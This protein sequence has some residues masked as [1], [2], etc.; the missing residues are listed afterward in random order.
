MTVPAPLKF[1]RFGLLAAAVAIVLPL[2]SIHAQQT[3]SNINFG[4]AGGSGDSSDDSWAIF[5]FGANSSSD[6]ISSSSIYGDI[7]A[8]GSGIVTFSGVTDTTDA[9]AST[10]NVYF[11]TNGT[12][13]GKG[14]LGT[15]FS[16]STT[17]S[18]LSAGVT[19]AQN[20][21]IEA[22]GLSS[23]PGVAVNAAG[24]TD[25]ASNGQFVLNI[26]N[27]TLSNDSSFTLN[28]TAKDSYVFNISGTF[29]L[30]NT[31]MILTGG[32]TASN[33]LFN[34][35]GTSGIS[36]SGGT[37]DGIILAASSN[38]WSSTAVTVAGGAQVNGSIIANKVSIAGGSTIQAVVS[39]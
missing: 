39:P 21:S 34:Y 4:A 2:H 33:V 38:N 18:L 9:G 12:F 13:T 20:A 22:S 6:S 17:N 32:L 14:F 16:N 19:A 11:T 8:A 15:K 23:A 35:T 27:F 7:G 26:T 31:K 37:T 1:S 30:S 36:I 28:G 25:T 3:L 5:T 10:S 24:Y 29:S